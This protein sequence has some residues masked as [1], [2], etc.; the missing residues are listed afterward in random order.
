[1]RDVRSVVLEQARAL[2]VMGELIDAATIDDQQQSRA[3]LIL[4]TNELRVWELS[5]SCPLR[6]VR[7]VRQHEPRDALRK[8]DCASHEGAAGGVESPRHVRLARHDATANVW[9]HSH[10]APLQAHT[11][12]LGAAGRFGV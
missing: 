11:S 6:R 8:I 1:M 4:Q 10:P 9:H 5:E 2:R 3:A 12:G 7:I